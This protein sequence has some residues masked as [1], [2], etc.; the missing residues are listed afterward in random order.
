[1]SALDAATQAWL[2]QEDRHTVETIRKY[3]T[4]IQY[5]GGAGHV[6]RAPFAYT[7]GLYGRFLAW[8]PRLRQRF[9]TISRR[10]SGTDPISFRA[11]F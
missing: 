10:V 5:V 1:M 9:S 6:E 3:G 8:G 2:D 7:V 4:Y 11:R